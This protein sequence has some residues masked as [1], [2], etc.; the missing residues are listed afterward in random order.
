[1]SAY[2]ERRSIMDKNFM[3]PVSIEKFAAYL[4][5]NLSD[6]EMNRIEALVSTNPDM[7]ELVAISDEVDEDIQVYMQ[8][9][10]A[11]EADMT[12]LEDSDFDIPNLEADLTPHV[13]TDTPDYREVACAADAADRI[14]DMDETTQLNDDDEEI[15]EDEFENND[16]IT[17]QDDGSFSTISA[18][19]GDN[20]HE[21]SDF[22]IEDDFLNS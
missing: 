3:P 8:D 16:F 15:G 17:H 21:P 18:N 11:Y 22:P 14:T 19:D 9:E 13:G 5:G 4:D 2:A 7:E 12:A 10:F 6:D 20:A 1:M